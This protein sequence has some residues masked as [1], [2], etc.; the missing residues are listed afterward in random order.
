MFLLGGSPIELGPATI[1]AFVA[2]LGAAF[3]YAIA[4]TFV[5]RRLADVAPLDLATGQ[6][7][8]AALIL[9]PVAL[10]T[11]I[12]AV[13]SPAASGSIV[14]M[15]LVSTAIAWP[16]YFRIAGRTSATAASSSTFVVPMFGILWGGLILGES[17]GAEL[18]LGFGLVIASL[19][20]V[21]RLPVPRPA[22]VGPV[23]GAARHALH[24]RDRGRPPLI[25][26]RPRRRRGGGVS[27]SR[28]P[29][30]RPRPGARGGS[31]T[32]SA[33]RRR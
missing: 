16:V 23:T 18:L 22:V 5:R 19:V 32:R 1:V 14:A 30:A 20:L 9:L 13:P 17:I 6:L 28:E 8:A 10:A 7:I 2:G 25:R 24:R 12:P 31:P 27:R 21:L 4:G 26:P 29:S 11:G 33:S 15:G 3:S